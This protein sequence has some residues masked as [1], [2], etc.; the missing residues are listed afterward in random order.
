MEEIKESKFEKYKRIK[1]LLDPK[2]GALFTKQEAKHIYA[3][4]IRRVEW[5]MGE[6][7]L[8]DIDDKEITEIIVKKAK[9]MAGIYFKRQAQ[10][11]A[12]DKITEL[13]VKAVNKSS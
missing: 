9:E 13:I 1:F 6:K 2:P 3:E 10:N 5:E 4:A 11:N 8:N 7:W 12:V